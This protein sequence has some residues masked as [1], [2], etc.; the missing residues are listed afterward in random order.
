ME[1]YEELRAQSTLSDN[2]L[3]DM[4]AFI[5][6]QQA[7]PATLAEG[8][9][10]YAANCAACHGESGAGDGQFAD[11]MK[12]SFEKTRDEHGIQPPTNFSNPEHLLEA[13]PALLQGKI[14]RGGMGTGMP[15]WGDI[16]TNQQTWDVVAYLYSFQFDY[17]K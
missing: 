15:M 1:A 8:K 14:L 13:S 7:S 6:Q 12:A 17:S 4:V 11:E 16:F 9:R 3:W 2:D 5:W 10:L